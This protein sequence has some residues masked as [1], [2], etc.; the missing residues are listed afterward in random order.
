MYA[1]LSLSIY[2]Y[3][4]THIC[5]QY[6][7]IYI[8]IYTHVHI[9]LIYKLLIQRINIINDIPINNIIIYNAIYAYD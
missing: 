2:L 1:S 5:I 6:V 3:I 7:C 9:L 4:Y 8:Y